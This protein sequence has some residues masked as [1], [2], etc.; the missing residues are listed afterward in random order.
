MVAA[1]GF[2]LLIGLGWI[3]IDNR[4]HWGISAAIVIGVTLGVTLNELATTHFETQD[5]RNSTAYMLDHLQPGDGIL[6]DGPHE[7]A[8]WHYYRDEDASLVLHNEIL[9]AL[10]AGSMSICELPYERLWLMTGDTLNAD[11]RNLFAD[12]HYQVTR[13]YHEIGVRLV[14]L[15]EC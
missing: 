8:F 3:Y 4:I 14:V 5:W 15:E 7:T 1:P 13:N 6:L 2:F 12:T 10:Y 9:D 11:V